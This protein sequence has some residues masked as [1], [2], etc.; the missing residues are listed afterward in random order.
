M[1]SRDC[2][3]VQKSQRVVKYRC[4]L[5]FCMARRQSQLRHLFPYLTLTLAHPCACMHAPALTPP[6]WKNP[7]LC[8][9]LP[10][11]IWRT[12]HP[13]HAPPLCTCSPSPLP[14]VHLDPY[15]LGMLHGHQVWPHHVL[16][17]AVAKWEPLEH[18]NHEC[19]YLIW[20]QDRSLSMQTGG[21]W[22]LPLVCH[23]VYRTL[24]K[25]PDSLMGTHQ[26]EPRCT[27]PGP[28]HAGCTP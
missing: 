4:P 14:P 13:I 3:R 8:T 11:C 18:C 24:H 15:W 9:H 6:A 5:P 20:V 25:R 16:P 21:D 1:T 28:I 7:Q 22:M 27:P 23:A 17:R 19:M 12:S 26:T 2:T 10:G